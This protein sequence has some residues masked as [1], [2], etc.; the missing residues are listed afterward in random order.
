MTAETRSL[1][2]ANQRMVISLP[3]APLGHRAALVAVNTGERQTSLFAQPTPVTYVY[4]A[5][6]TP[7]IAVT[8][9]SALPAGVEAQIEITGLN[10]QF[11]EGQVQAGFHTSDAVVRRLWVLSPT[12]LLANVWLAPGVAPGMLPLTVTCGLN[13]ITTQGA[14]QVGAAN[15]RLMSLSPASGASGSIVPVTVNGLTPGALIATVNDR[16]AGVV[17]VNGNVVLIQLPAGL[18]AGPA[19]VRLISGSEQSLPIAISIEP[20]P[21]IIIA[22]FGNGNVPFDANRPARPGETVR[23]MV[24]GLSDKAEVPLA[25]VSLSIAGIEH[26]PAKIV[27][28]GG[29]GGHEVHVV[30]Q[31]TVAPGNAQTTVSIDGTRTS[32][33]FALPVRQ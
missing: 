13:T 8:S 12:R 2:E 26:A 33:P 21:P 23:L 27:P 7:A 19:T 6:E 28:L 29:A 20:P 17:G 25:R 11:A 31:A 16:P 15:P 30:L 18:P 5:A 22:A 9:G 1:D 32:S 14:L 10:T 24:Q 3:N 4:D